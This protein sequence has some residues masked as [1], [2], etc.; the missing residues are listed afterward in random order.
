MFWYPKTV[1]GWEIKNS[2]THRGSSKY[3]DDQDGRTGT[4]ESSDVIKLEV[5]KI[6]AGKCRTNLVR[7][8]GGGILQRLPP[9]N[10]LGNFF[11]GQK[12]R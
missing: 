8:G 5:P 4:P 12:D 9:T 1:L 7:D 2:L 6:S 3:D 10:A 11:D